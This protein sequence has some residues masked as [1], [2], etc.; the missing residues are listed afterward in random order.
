MSTQEFV[1]RIEA[2]LENKIKKWNNATQ[3]TVETF[4]QSKGGAKKE[5]IIIEE[6]CEHYKRKRKSCQR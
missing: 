1:E 3:S 5:P 2:R 4:G 6:Y